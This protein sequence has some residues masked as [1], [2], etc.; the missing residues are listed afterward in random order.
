MVFTIVLLV[1]DAVLLVGAALFTYESLRENEPRAPKV[2]WA[3]VGAAIIAAVLILAAPGLRE[4]LALVLGVILIA[5]LALLIPTKPNARALKGSLGYAVDEVKPH[6]ERDVV[7]AR[8]RSLPPGSELYRRY[9]EMHPE[10]EARDADR[11]KKGGPVGRP[12][13]IDRGY[14]PNVSMIA[15]T[16]A[17]P[18]MLGPHA[19]AQPVSTNSPHV[20]DPARASEIVKKFALHLGASQVGVCRVNPKWG[21]SHRGE[22]FYDNWEDWGKEL[23]EVPPFAVVIATEMDPHNVGAGPH[24]P[25]VVESGV[26]YAKGAYITTIL[27]GWFAQMGYRASADHS[28]HYDTCVVPL[29]I[30]AGLGEMGRLGYLI[31]SRTGPRAR[32]FAVLTDMPLQ[33]DKPVDLGAEAFCTVCKKCATSCPSRS[34]PRGRQTVHNGIEKWKMDEMS[35]FDYWGQIGTDCSICMGICPYS[36]PN[37]SIH[38]VVR[39]MI[40]R[41][42]LAKKILPHIDNFVYGQRWRSRRPAQWIDY[43]EPTGHSNFQE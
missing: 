18:A 40:A 5:C 33:T 2:G 39:W 31:T 41:S 16:F 43:R 30:D 26:N 7:F 23:P 27:A 34:I 6:D 24:T 21:Y 9:Y 38:K 35:C 29:A 36:R 42:L 10:L 13:S 22:I 11:R 4:P 17:L 14:R 3:C 25:A 15:T 8:N 20:L 1:A 28:R 32:L 37:R 12:G 19:K